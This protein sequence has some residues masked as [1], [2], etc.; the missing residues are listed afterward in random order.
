M[1]NLQDGLDAIAALMAAQRQSNRLLRMKFPN[2]DAPSAVL[3]PM[4]RGRA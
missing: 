2:D 1:T 4:P 3:L